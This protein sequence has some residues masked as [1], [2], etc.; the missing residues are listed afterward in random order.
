MVSDNGPVALDVAFE[1]HED[2]HAP[3]L[4]RYT[5]LADLILLD[6]HQDLFGP[7]P[8]Q[9]ISLNILSKANEYGD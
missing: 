3:N 1:A 8:K 4:E 6:P 7:L 5:D 9:L 2:Y